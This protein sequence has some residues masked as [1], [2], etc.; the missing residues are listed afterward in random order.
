VA[1]QVI[2]G[3]YRFRPAPIAPRAPGLN[4]QLLGSGSILNEVLRAQALLAERYGIAA[5]V[6]SAPSYQLLRRDA[7]KA[8]RWN[9]L[10]PAAPPRRPYVGE[11][12]DDTPG[13][14]IAA[15]D[16]MKAVPD[17]IAR[18]VRGGLTSLGTDGYGRSDTREALRRHFEVDAESIV[19]AT[20]SR[21]KDIGVISA[22]V[23]HHAIT[24]L[25]IDTEG[26]DP[27]EA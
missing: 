4:A 14:V 22:D 1:D 10:H 2:R 27:Q 16:Y 8:E 13:P 15:S 19:I 24:E 26:I 5:D 21:L 7:L 25:G 20:L 11:Q 12:L 23:V 3:L 9:R 6:W 18:W 17:Q